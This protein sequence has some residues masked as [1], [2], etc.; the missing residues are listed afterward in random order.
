MLGAISGKMVS[1]SLLLLL[2]LVWFCVLRQDLTLSVTWELI[3]ISGFQML[4]LQAW[5]TVPGGNY[6]LEGFHL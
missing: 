5:V 1:L 2:L 6:A 3:A 4:G